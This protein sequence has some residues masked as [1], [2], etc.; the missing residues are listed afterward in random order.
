[1]ASDVNHFRVAIIILPYL[2]PLT[3]LYQTKMS[4]IIALMEQDFQERKDLLDLFMV[5]PKKP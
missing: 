1:M 3:I 2:F 5:Q 4:L